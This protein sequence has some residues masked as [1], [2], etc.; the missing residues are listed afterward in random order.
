MPCTVKRMAHTA[1]PCF[2]WQDSRRTSLLRPHQL[3][4]SIASVIKRISKGV[5][6]V[7]LAIQTSFHVNVI[8][9]VAIHIHTH[10]HKQTH[11][12][13]SQKKTILGSQVHP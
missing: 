8:Y 3:R 4:I 10:I 12:P 5:G 1:L 2:P 11:K 6:L 9:H 7:W 13:T